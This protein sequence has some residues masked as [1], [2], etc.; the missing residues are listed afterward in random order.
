MGQELNPG[1]AR[2][3]PA[4]RSQVSGMPGAHAGRSV[5]TVLPLIPGHSL[6]DTGKYSRGNYE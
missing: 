6:L 4:P 1:A 2:A 3:S 5:L